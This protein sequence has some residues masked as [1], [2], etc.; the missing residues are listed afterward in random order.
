[1]TDPQIVTTL[2]S[3]RDH[4]ESYIRALE[5]KIEEARHDLAHVNAT[6]RLFELD[7]GQGDVPVYMGTRRI[8][9]YGEI[10]EICSMALVDAPSGLDT[11]ELALTVI[12]AKGLDESD[13]VLRKTVAHSIVDVLLQRMRRGKIASSGKRKGV[14]VWQIRR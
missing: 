11:R 8:F 1:M 13:P 7:G 3:K 14:R 2:R 10:F 6:L 5:K 9:K 4:I 12:K